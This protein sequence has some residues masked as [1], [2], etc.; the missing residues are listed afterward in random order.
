MP[1]GSPDRPISPAEQAGVIRVAVGVE[2]GSVADATMTDAE[3][4]NVGS[5]K[6]LVD[7]QE[8]GRALEVL[9]TGF[10]HA[11]TWESTA[12]RQIQTGFDATTGDRK[13][14]SPTE[15][16][17]FRR[18][19]ETQDVYNEYLK[20][21]YEGLIDESA[22]GGKSIRQKQDMLAGQ[23]E[24]FI[25]SN[26]AIADALPKDWTGNVDR[27]V[28]RDAVERVLKDPVFRKQLTE[29]LNGLFDPASLPKD[30]EAQLLT[31]ENKLNST[32][33]EVIR[34]EGLQSQDEAEKNRQQ[35]RKIK[36]DTES[37]TSSNGIVGGTKKEV[38][39]NL[40][41]DSEIL[42]YKQAQKHLVEVITGLG[43]GRYTTADR[44][45]AEAAVRTAK[46]PKVE[47]HEILLNESGDINTKF[48]DVER[49]LATTATE[50]LAKRGQRTSVK[51]EADNLAHQRRAKSQEFSD[52]VTGAIRKTAQEYLVA[53]AR[54]LISEYPQYK[55]EITA[56]LK[57]EADEKIKAQADSRWI[58]EREE[59]WLWR[60]R[61]VYSYNEKMTQ[62]DVDN[63][64][65]SLSTQ[66]NPDMFV[67]TFLTDA[68]LTVEQIAQLKQDKGFMEAQRSSLVAKLL[69]AHVAAGGQINETTQSALR[70]TPWGKKVSAEWINNSS[71]AKQE[72]ERLTGKPVSENSLEDVFKKK[73]SKGLVAA[74]LLA[75]GIAMVGKGI[76]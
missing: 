31:A 42:A 72:V 11:T 49:S 6:M 44:T 62:W 57:A 36:F 54:K 70:M 8:G 59:G 2:T 61:T 41:I 18:V 1:V 21:G 45:A 10:N 33:Q 32:S 75:L 51:T 15:T 30:L 67:E 19:R 63:V 14:R 24:D 3:R 53:R 22:Y 56:S 13:A 71:E 47:E 40:G 25:K 23:A 60:K 69:T 65:N 9:A 74:L 7:Q 20:S 16:D 4:A 27:Y 66:G 12:E 17:N 29:R 68:G 48:K 39:E 35:A 50:L 55:T 38:L 28:M 52:E 64:L 26:A 58:E 73:G 43:G 5:F 37:Y 46:T 34:L 76:F